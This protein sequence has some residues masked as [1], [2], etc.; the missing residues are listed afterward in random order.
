MSR[1]AWCLALVGLSSILSSTVSALDGRKPG[2]VL[3]YPIQRSG[4]GGFTIVSVTN[5]ALEAENQFVLGG[6]TNI[7]YRYLNV[8]PSGDE[9]IPADCQVLEITEYL[10]PGDTAAVLTSC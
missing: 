10:T 2:S 1:W 3:I 6:G 7:V 8:S 9:L 4:S 5:T